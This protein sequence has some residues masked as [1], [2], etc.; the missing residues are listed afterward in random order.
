MTIKKNLAQ[1]LLFIESLLDKKPE[2]T[3]LTS[4]YI[5]SMLGFT[6]KDLIRETG[7]KFEIIG[8]CAVTLPNIQSTPLLQGDAFAK[9]AR[10][11]CEKGS[12]TMGQF[13]FQGKRFGVFHV[14]VGP[15][16]KPKNT[17]HEA[18]LKALAEPKAH[19]STRLDKTGSS[20]LHYGALMPVEMM[21]QLTQI[22]PEQALLG[23]DFGY[24]PIHVAAKCGNTAVVLHLLDLHPTLLNATNK[25]GDTPLLVATRYRHTAVVDALLERRASQTMLHNGLFPLWV[26][27]QNESA[28]IALLL[29]KQL[30]PAQASL[31]V[32]SGY[33][34]LHMAITKHLPSVAHALVAMGV[35]LGSK[36]K[37]DGWTPFHMA[38]IV[39]DIALLQAM[40]QRDPSLINL[41]LESGKCALHLAAEMGHLAVVTYLL[42]H[43]ARLDKK[44]Y[45]VIR[46]YTWR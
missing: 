15:A 40:L 21:Q 4:H 45:K 33:T 17:A 34:P 44:P 8:G 36:T 7:D 30:T 25:K 10:S 16:L 41:A 24:L 14:A 38:V 13:V 20:L 6:N 26:S 31:A 42:E 22:A 1:P 35:D 18:L 43:S 27:I 5:H 39:A 37:S 28:E 9:A 23:D 19:M 32:D 12:E 3:Q 2:P 11:A 29:I 46:L